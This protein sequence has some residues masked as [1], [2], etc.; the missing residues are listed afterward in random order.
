MQTLK[1]AGFN[2][3]WEYAFKPHLVFYEKAFCNYNCTVCM[4]V[5]PTG[6]IQPLRPEDKQVTQIGIARFVR[7]LCIVRTD[8]TSCGA[9]AKQCPVKAVRM[10]PFRGTLTI[11]VVYPELC[12][13]CGGCE[14]ACPV[15]PVKAINVIPKA[16]H[17]IAQRPEAGK[18]YHP[19]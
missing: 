6:A 16:V 10:E 5:C 15:R 8:N 18:H 19:N 2:F 12:I 1:P 3:G 14:S 13:G 4:Q 11:P 7:R 17:G 9:C